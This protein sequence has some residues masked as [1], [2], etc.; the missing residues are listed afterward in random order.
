MGAKVRGSH[1][2]GG[3]NVGGLRIGGV[4]TWTVALWQIY[5]EEALLCGGVVVI[6]S[7][8]IREFG[9]VA[10]WGS[11]GKRKLQ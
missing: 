10:P 8:S 9:R 4:V 11:C 6:G 1:G 5:G 2:V 3:C 7:C